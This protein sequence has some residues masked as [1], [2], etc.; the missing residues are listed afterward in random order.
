MNKISFMDK[1]HLQ[2]TKI[3]HHIS[4]KALLCRC[5]LHLNSPSDA[6]GIM[7]K[8]YVFLVCGKCSSEWMICCHCPVRSQK[9]ISTQRQFVQHQKKLKHHNTVVK[10]HHAV[11]V[12]IPEVPTTHSHSS[13]LTE[14]TELSSNN[15]QNSKQ[16]SGGTMSVKTSSLNNNDQLGFSGSSNDNYFQCCTYDN[17]LG[18]E[19]LVR[20]SILKNDISPH[21]YKCLS[22]FDIPEDQVDL[23]LRMARMSFYLP[24]SDKDDTFAMLLYDIYKCG[25][26]RGHHCASKAINE[27]FNR[28]V[29]KSDVSAPLDYIANQC[30]SSFNVDNMCWHPRTSFPVGIPKKA[31]EI[32]DTFTEGKYSIIENLPHPVVKDDLLDKGWSYVSILD[33]LRDFLGHSHACFQ[34]I[35]PGEAPGRQECLHTSQSVRAS[36]IAKRANKCTTA[37]PSIISYLV[38]WNDDVDLSSTCLQGRANATV[39]TMTIACP[40]DDNNRLENTY[41]IA[42]GEKDAPLD[43]IERKVIDELELLCDFPKFYV[44]SSKSVQTAHFERLCS[45]GD[46]PARRSANYCTHGNG[47]FSAQ[48]GRSADCKQLYPK[49]KSCQNCTKKLVT[50]F[51]SCSSWQQPIPECDICLNWDTLNDSNASLSLFLPPKDYPCDD[52]DSLFPKGRVIHRDDKFYLKPFRVSYKSMMQAIELAHCKFVDDI[53]NKHNCDA[54]LKVEGLNTAIIDRFFLHATRAKALHLCPNDSDLKAEAASNPCSFAMM[55][56]PPQWIGPGVDL[57]S[58]VEAVMHLQFLGVVKTVMKTLQ[59]VLAARHAK[60]EFTNNIARKRSRKLVEIKVDWFKFREYGGNKFGGWISESYVA[61]GKVMP[62]FYQDMMTAIPIK[63]MDIQPPA[64]KHQSSWTKKENLHWLKSRGLDTK[65]YASDLRER[66][67]QYLSGDEVPQ[68]LPGCDV[69]EK[70]IEDTVTALLD[71]L[72]CTMSK[73]V[74]DSHIQR[75]DYAIR[76]FLSKF[77]SLDSKLGGKRDRVPAVISNYNFQSLMNIP[78]VMKEFGPLPYLW[79]GKV[80]GEGFLPQLKKFPWVGKRKNWHFHLLTKF[81]KDKA[82]SNILQGNSNKSLATRAPINNGLHA[83]SRQIHKH[84]SCA[85]IYDRLNETEKLSK[86]PLFVIFVCSTLRNEK[87]N[88][89]IFSCAGDYNQFIELELNTDVPTFEKLGLVYHTIQLKHKR[90]R[91]HLKPLAWNIDIWPQLTN[92]RLGFG[93]ALP[94]MEDVSEAKQAQFAVLSSNWEILTREN[95]M[96]DLIS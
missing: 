24:Q 68:P 42:I 84:T 20:K 58:H 17:K 39:R 3:H 57:M 4:P 12:T 61:M 86:K 64:N 45:L 83:F 65:G 75:T 25:L 52:M 19:F 51:K 66:V 67:A 28:L 70:D 96:E 60:S 47:T 72:R 91:N 59:K 34:S 16:L 82:F 94:L 1:S 21:L 23:H 74:N 40:L 5:C 85:D 87:M 26:E 50:R 92:P 10:D 78:F 89:R 69:E 95:N 37:L 31:S 15:W 56:Y 62:W 80:Q 63:T 79:E 11:K 13:E 73:S 14:Q 9:Q 22:F 2:A 54:F 43:V 35:N 30:S 32:R 76:I 48:F 38:F 93:L 81:Y 41:C 90:S 29:D 88:A 7:M 53:W 77:D 36:H 8:Y 55:Q 27:Q 46:Q 44:G 71:M 33:C 6:I 18:K 49:L